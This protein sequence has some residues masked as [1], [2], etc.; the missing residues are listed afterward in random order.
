M[1]DI[2]LTDFDLDDMPDYVSCCLIAKR[3]GGKG[4]LT[5]SLCFHHFKNKV[6]TAF[7]FSPTSEIANNPMDFVPMHY[8]YKEFDP[9]VVERIL[10]RQEFL[11]RNDPKGNHHTLLIVDDIMATLDPKSQKVLDKIFVAG[12][13]FQISIV[14][15][16]QYVKREFSTIMRTNC[17][18]VFIFNQT[19]YNNKESLVL[20][21]LSTTENKKLGFALMNKYAD[22]Y[23][24]LVVNNTSTSNDYEDFCFYFKADLIKRKFILG[25]DF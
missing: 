13:H 12:R 5:K 16:F 24:C 10:T 9:D 1:S 18:Y 6:K 8:R 2:E 25:K 11:I 4:V 23:Q 3:R 20:D 7:L 21:Y 14:V 15:C 19:N 17:D 22:G